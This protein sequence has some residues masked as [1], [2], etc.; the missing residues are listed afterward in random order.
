MSTN[1]ACLDAETLAAWMD[2]GLDPA[3]VAAVESHVSTC[4]RCQSLVA[5]FARTEPLA[6]GTQVPG[7]SFLWRWWMAPLAATAA[8]VVLW[9]VVPQQPT[10]PLAPAAPSPSITAERN[11][12]SQP[13]AIKPEVAQPSARPTPAPVD[14]LKRN[15]PQAEAEQKFADAARDRDLGA[16]AGNR[17]QREKKEAAGRSAGAA[18]MAESAPAR[19][20]PARE[21]PAAAPP[22]AAAEAP[23][24]FQRMA[25]AAATIDIVSSDPARRWRIAAGGTIEHSS[26]GGRTWAQVHAAGEAIAAGSSPLPTVCWLVGR[27]GTVLLTTDAVTFARV[28]APANVDLVGVA[29]TSDRAATVTAADG[30]AFRTNDA[31]QTWQR[32]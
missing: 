15:A 6:P 9:M 31:G 1:H 26:D 18:L 29:A 14:E 30:R 25:K 20:E 28:P 11:A 24:A 32:Q 10:N 2:G 22:P 3:S 8:A 23:A 7:T 12:A 5:T 19:A 16:A 21:A 4:P 17:E 13:D 27:S